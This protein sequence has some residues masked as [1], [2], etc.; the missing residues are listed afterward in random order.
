M[1]MWPLV[2][3]TEV[4]LKLVETTS[5]LFLPAAGTE[6]V[7]TPD[8]WLVK[9]GN[10][11]LRAD[12]ITGVVDQDGDL[13]TKYGHTFKIL[14]DVGYTVSIPEYGTST[15]IPATPETVTIDCSIFLEET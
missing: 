13:K 11:A 7:F 6:M 10:V 15:E 5:G 14:S 1:D 4:H 8:K 9:A 12:E 3:L 2:P